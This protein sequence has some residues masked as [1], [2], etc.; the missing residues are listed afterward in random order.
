[1]LLIWIPGKQKTV[2]S[3]KP[4]SRP[5]VWQGYLY[6]VWSPDGDW[7]IGLGGDLHHTIGMCVVN[8]ENPLLR[9]LIDDELDD[10]V[11]DVTWVR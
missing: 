7:I 4:S 10:L 9:K 5:Y 6:P 3:T 1:M 2:L 11:Q 8:V